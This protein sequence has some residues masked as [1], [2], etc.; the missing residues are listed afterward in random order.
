MTKRAS[1]PSRRTY[2]DQEIFAELRLVGRE[3]YDD[4]GVGPSAGQWN[5][6]SSS[7]APTAYL[8]VRQLTG[9]TN[10]RTHPSRKTWKLILDMASLIQPTHGEAIAIAAKK[11]KD[12]TAAIVKIGEIKNDNGGYGL[13]VIPIIRPVLTWC[14]HTHRYIKT[15]GVHHTLMIR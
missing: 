1:S 6:F 14:V 13:P 12:Q 15:G 11:R 10:A 2:T 5:T 8:I 4:I 7:D 9:K 3:I